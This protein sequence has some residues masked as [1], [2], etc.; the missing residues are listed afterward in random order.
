MKKIYLL[1][2]LTPILTS[3]GFKQIDEGYRGIPLHWGKM[4]GEPV[5]PGLH[6]YNPFSSSMLEL[7]VRE[8]RNSNKTQAF[9]SDNQTVTIEYSVTYYPDPNKIGA[10]YSQFGEKW[11][12]KIVLQAVLGSMKDAIGGYKADDL[13]QN[14]EGVT[15]KAEGVIRMALA[16]RGVTLT[17]LDM[18]NLDF[19]EAYEKAAE[20]KVTAI[21]KAIA[22]KNRTV[23]IEEQAKQTV[24][25]AV[26]QAE[27]MKIKTAALSQNK[28]LVQYEAVQKWNGVL[29]Q[30]V[31][32]NGATPIIDLR[33]LGK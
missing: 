10:L 21:Q 20:E 4:D 6:F 22:E 33:E 3:C 28:S 31:L 26:A 27:A 25:S 19:E 5:G 16:T 17:R 7:S 30:M 18:T 2:L 13:I 8:E 14:R 9:T 29:P 24:K 32:G 15:K 1:L 11:E 12:D 23:Q